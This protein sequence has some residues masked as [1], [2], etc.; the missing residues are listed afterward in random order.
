MKMSRRLAAILA[1]FFLSCAAGAEAPAADKTLTVQPVTIADEKAVFAS[2]QSLNV[3]PARA[4]IDGTVAEVKVQ[5]GD[6]VARDQVVALI[7]D[8]KLALRLRSLAAQE[9]SAQSQLRQAE[10]D[11]AR[12]QKL[13]PVGGISKSGL[14]EAQTAVK[15]AQSD[16]QSQAAQRSVIEQQMREGQVLT[17][18]PGR[19]L[20]VPVTAG[21][22]VMAGDEI[23]SV[24]R[25]NY[26]LRLQVPERQGRLLKVGGTVR[27]DG[28]DLVNGVA[29]NGKIT[30]IYPEVSD[31]RVEVDAEVEGLG[32]YFVGERVRVWIAA[33]ERQ[34]FVVPSDYIVTRFGIDY[35]RL[36][37]KGG[38]IDAPV[39][40][41]QLSGQGIEILSGLSAGD[42]LVHP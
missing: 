8:E 27:I 2:V 37:T 3:V 33:G 6:S 25:A 40:R 20:K 10:S 5:P 24:A 18:A 39:Q 13:E 31:G 29:Q 12:A 16:V 21:S 42:V 26:V 4:R 9:A 22:V 7:G 34:A 14:E 28:A 36:K 11:L 32:N 17:P 1:A 38:V 15:V 19:V 23:A 30:L 35:V 41:G